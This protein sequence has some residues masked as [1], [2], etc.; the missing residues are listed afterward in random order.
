VL[1]KVGRVS[2]AVDLAALLVV[3][4]M[5]G[6]TRLY[7]AARENRLLAHLRQ[8]LGEMRREQEMEKLELA[9]TQQKSEKAKLQ[10]NLEA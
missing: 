9:R 2:I 7:L 8:R 1:R 10:P 6:V 3:L 5:L 4:V